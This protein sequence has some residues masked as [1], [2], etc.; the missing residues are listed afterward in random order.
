M[1]KLLARVEAATGPDREIDGAL[2]LMEGW[3][4]QKMKGDREPYWRKPGATEY[5]NR[6]TL[7]NY[8]ASI[9]AALALVERMLP[10]WRKDAPDRDCL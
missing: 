1:A 8:T 10:G 3:T 5:W 7:I 4:F 2:A 6:S 9:D